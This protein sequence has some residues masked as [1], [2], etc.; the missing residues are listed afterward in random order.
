[1]AQEMRTGALASRY[2][3]TRGNGNIESHN[4]TS[5]DHAIFV[6]NDTIF[7]IVMTPFFLQLTLNKFSAT[8]VALYISKSALK[9][10]NLTLKVIRGVKID[11][12]P[13]NLVC[14]S[15]C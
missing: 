13:V 15:A 6:K 12:L 14:E 11:K 4:T 8:Y 5:G 10:T 1:M 7:R 9:L 3:N 2:C